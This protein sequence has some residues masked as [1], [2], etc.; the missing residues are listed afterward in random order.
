VNP[1]TPSLVAPLFCIILFYMP[2]SV[3]KILIH[4]GDIIRAAL[5]PIGSGIVIALIDYNMYDIAF[6]YYFI[7][8][9]LSEGVVETCNKEFKRIRLHH[10]RKTSG[11][12]TNTDLFQ[13]LL[14]L[15][16]PKIS[17]IRKL[18]KKKTT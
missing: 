12:N 8:G 13:I 9:Q 6:I 1:G 17:T 10:T 11:V 2:S 14:V 16:D 15:S 7:L 18:P 5:L 4:G 3:H